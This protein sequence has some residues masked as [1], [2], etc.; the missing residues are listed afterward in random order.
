[1]ATTV[2]DDPFPSGRRQRVATERGP[3]TTSARPHV[4]EF[5]LHPLKVLRFVWALAH[6]PRV[7]LVRKVVYLLVEGVLL[8]ALLVPEGVVATLVAGLLPLVGPL[9]AV[10]ADATVDWLFLGA[11]AYA[12]LGLFPAQIVREH[13]ARI[14][15]PTRGRQS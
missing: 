12:L 5:V 3:S 13:H 9:V 4:W 8:V 6:D 15:H 1:M 7:S 2:P 14:F 11:T 10:P